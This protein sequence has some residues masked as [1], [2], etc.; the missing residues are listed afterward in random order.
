MFC[1]SIDE[2]PSY[3][4]EWVDATLGFPSRVFELRPLS[5]SGFHQAPSDDDEWS[6]H[7]STGGYEGGRAGYSLESANDDDRWSRQPR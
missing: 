2:Q 4:H 3:S 7:P 6:Q 1:G 5:E